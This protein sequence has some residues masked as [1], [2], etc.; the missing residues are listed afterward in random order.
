MGKEREIRPSHR[1]RGQYARRLLNHRPGG[2][3]RPPALNDRILAALEGMEENEETDGNSIESLRSAYNA[4]R[5]RQRAQ[6][7]GQAQGRLR[8]DGSLRRGQ[9]EDVGF[10]RRVVRKVK[11]WFTSDE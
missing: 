2:V 10:F 6:G 11:G 1:R 3:D 7:H 4:E 9:R 5:L 8:E